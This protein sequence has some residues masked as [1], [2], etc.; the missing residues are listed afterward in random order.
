MI[1]S[2]CF[3][4][5]NQKINCFVGKHS[6]S[7]RVADQIKILSF[8]NWDI[9]KDD[10]RYAVKSEGIQ[11][12]FIDPITCFTNQMKASETNEFLMAMTAELSSMALDMDFTSYIF[13]HLKAP[14]SGPPHERGGK[15][16][17]HQFAGSRA[18]MRV[19]NYM[20]GLEGNKDP[21]LPLEER[22]VRDLI[23][24][25]DR[26]FGEAAKIRLYWDHKTGIFTEIMG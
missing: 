11:D 10:I 21:D 9:I 17:S 25:E 20:I 22:N 8:L 5:Q 24:L 23:I 15:V 7:G 6:S 26:E 19:C 18:M 4:S 2:C 13:C 14:E 3:L 12:I 1:F 16:L